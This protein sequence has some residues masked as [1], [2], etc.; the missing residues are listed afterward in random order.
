MPITNLDPVIAAAIQQGLLLPGFKEPMDSILAFSNFTFPKKI[1]ANIGTLVKFTQSARLPVDLTPVSASAVTSNLDNG[2]TTQKAGIEQYEL[3]LDEWDQY[4]K[5]EL[6][7]DKA[8]IASDLRRCLGN[9]G[10]HA[11]TRKDRLVRK[12]YLDF[13]LGGNSRVIA[14]GNTTAAAHVDDIR[15]FQK[16]LTTGGELKDVSGGNPITVNEYDANGNWVQSFTVTGAVAD[17]SNVS[18]LAANGLG[19]I[20]GVLTISPVAGAAPTVGNALVA[21]KAPK[22]MRAGAKPHSGLISGGDVV[23]TDLMDDAL[24]YLRNQGHK[25]DIYAIAGASAMRQL[26]RDPQFLLAYQGRAEMPE[27]RKAK[28]TE[29]GG[30]KYLETT[31]VPLSAGAS[32]YQVGRI[33][34]I[35]DKDAACMEAVY[36]GFDQ[37]VQEKQSDNSVHYEK[38]Q[39]NCALFVPSPIDAK[40]RVQ[41]IGYS[42][43]TG[44]TCGSDLKA[45]S[46]IIPTASNS[47][48][49]KALWVEHVQ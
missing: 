12:A 9:L 30:I 35:A 39:D 16:A 25:G 33:L 13:Y 31:E 5:V 34:L 20:S 37:F 22:V 4:D 41:P 17:G 36:E 18:S 3:T 14:T 38:I 10:V 42:M 44:F 48:Y 32:G 47:M 29:F 23:T 21:A 46:S 27:L 24:T 19:G 1:R 28:V 8:I 6:L 2:M 43:V 15:G 49:K 40:R 7:Q 45:D 26:R 11:A